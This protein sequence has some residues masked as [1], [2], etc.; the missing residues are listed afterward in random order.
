MHKHLLNPQ[1]PCYI[2][3]STAHLSP[4]PRGTS[5]HARILVNEAVTRVRLAAGD[6]LPPDQPGATAPRLGNRFPNLRAVEA[7]DCKDAPVTDEGLVAFL[8]D[9]GPQVRL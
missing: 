3:S 7:Y 6:L 8:C 1:L 9:C 2:S 4:T 5:P